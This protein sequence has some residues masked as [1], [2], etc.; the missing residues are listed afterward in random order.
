MHQQLYLEYSKNQKSNL[1][2]SPIFDID[3][4]I[5]TPDALK[6]KRLWVG[7]REE[8]RDGKKTKVPY[9]ARTGGKAMADN[10][11]T[12]STYTEAGKWAENNCDLGS[13]YLFGPGLEFSPIP[14]TNFHTAG[15]D[16]DTCRD[17]ETEVIEPWANYIIE[18]F[19]SY[20]ISPS[21]TGVKIFFVYD[22]DDF[23]TIKALFKDG[24]G[25]MM[26]K[27]Q[28][29]TGHPPGIEVY[30]EKQFFAFT[31]AKL[32]SSPAELRVVDPSE[33]EWIV[34]GVGPKFKDSATKSKTKSSGDQSNSAK[35]FSL[36]AKLK[37]EGKTYE[38]MRDALLSSDDGGIA[39]WAKTKGM[40][41]GER[42]MH[43]IFDKANGKQEGLG[44]TVVNMKGI[45]KTVATLE[46]LNKRFA[47]LEVL[48]E[49][50]VYVSRAD[51]LPIKDDDLQRRL[52]DEVVLLGHQYLPAA[53][54]WKESRG[55][56]IYRRIQFTNQNVTEDTFNLFRG[57]GVTAKA[58]SCNLIKQ[59]I[60]EVI[61]SSDEKSYEA[62]LSLMA[63]QLQN[64]GSLRG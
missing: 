1:N 46:D 19:A 41:N 15:I 26:F 50:S 33:F 14:G 42:E 49:P 56:H 59:H 44:E 43:R 60:F 30:R 61:C 18:R 34:K 55:K 7:W 28:S 62:M 52:E 20:T 11:S 51:Y 29:E 9:N 22:M 23:L 17:P 5:I 16:L 10:S 57:L 4:E 37:W 3:Q 8:I 53:Y 47:R 27:R 40:L 36:G 6:A 31:E 24:Q 32:E 63:W 21:R 38:E 12:W 54:A 13:D 48:G 2:A 64:I 25:G 35:A 45:S 39:D 58:G